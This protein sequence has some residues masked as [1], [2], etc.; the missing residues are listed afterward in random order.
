[1]TRALL[2]TDIL[3]E[4]MKGKDLRVAE[5]GRAYLA[6]HGRYT[7]SAAQHH[8]LHIPRSTAATWRSRGPRPVVTLQEFDQDRQQLLDRVEKLRRRTQVLAAVVRLL[9]ALLG[10]SGFRLSG[11]RLPSGDDKARLL[12]AIAGAHPV[13]PLALIL[14]IVGMTPSRY[15]AWRRA[16][17]VCGLDDRPSCPRSM[18]SR[19]PTPLA[20]KMALLAFSPSA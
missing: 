9:L 13:L 6:T 5:R 11:E 17:E 20:Q 19:L 10:I 16:T 1:M 2:D 14:R 12:R 15:H 8:R 3:S 18:P 4:L 7:V